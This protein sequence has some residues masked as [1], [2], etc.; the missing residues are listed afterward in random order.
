MQLFARIRQ[1]VT[2]LISKNYVNKII[3]LFSLTLC[4]EEVHPD[5]EPV[6]GMKHTAP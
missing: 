4:S 1:K 3:Y 5:L 6:H 2:F